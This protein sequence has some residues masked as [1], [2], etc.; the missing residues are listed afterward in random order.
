[1]DGKCLCLLGAGYIPGLRRL[2][3]LC[4]AEVEAFLSWLANAAGVL[5]HS[6]A[7]AFGA[8]VLLRKGTRHE[9]VLDEGDRAP[10]RSSAPAD[11]V[12]PR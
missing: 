1:M 12:Q 4:T 10:T 3:T 2:S 7:G 6:Q 9:S 5:V 8:A 11:G